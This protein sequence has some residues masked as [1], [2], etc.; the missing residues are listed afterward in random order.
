M[1]GGIPGLKIS[2]P[3]R[4]CLVDGKW[5]TWSMFSSCSKSCGEGRKQR[6]RLCNSP[7]PLYGG[8]SCEG[9]KVDVRSCIVRMCFINNPGESI[10]LLFLS[11]VFFPSKFSNELNPILYGVFLTPL[12]VEKYGFHLSPK[13]KI[14]VTESLP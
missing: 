10:I 11:L 3:Y 4:V 14:Y 12:T 5:S 9:D 1:V 6:I 2:H 13:A 7:S 8:K